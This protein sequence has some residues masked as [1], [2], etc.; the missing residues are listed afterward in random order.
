MI[1]Q[2]KSS[3][4]YIAVGIDHPLIENIYAILKRGEMDKGDWQKGD[5][6][7][8]QWNNPKVEYLIIN[9]DEPYAEDV[10]K[11]LEVW[12]QNNQSIPDQGER[13]LQMTYA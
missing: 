2:F 11:E 6:S 5:I 13:D 10:K 3:Q 9:F 8:E 4:A 1:E 12:Q 7:F